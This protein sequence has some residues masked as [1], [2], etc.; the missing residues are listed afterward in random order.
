MR[1]AQRRLLLPSACVVAAIAM[2]ACAQQP[3]APAAPAEPTAEQAK[4]AQVERGR[5]LIAG[6]GCHDCHSPKVMTPQGPQIDQTKIL[7]GH[8]ASLGAVPP[9]KGDGGPYTTHTN[10]H[11]TA[12]SGAWGVSYAANLTP[13]E[14]T[15]LGIWTEQMFID[16]IKQGKHMGTS[17]PILPPMPW[18]EYKHL[19]DE[20]LKAM[21]AYLKSI[22]PIAN[23][24]PTPLDPTGK[25][26]DD[27]Q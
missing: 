5:L 1:V 26:I 23:R 24:V 17:R 10:D 25:S 15:G 9:F 21:L 3:A 16:A 13:D 11:L 7:S 18:N 8:P 20:D 6:G 27:I 19:P 12:W 14:N 4:A 2:A 22:P